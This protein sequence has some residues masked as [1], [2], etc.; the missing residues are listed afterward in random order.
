[1]AWCARG[2]RRTNAHTVRIIPSYPRMVV[3]LSLPY[4]RN[5]A[6]MIYYRATNMVCQETDVINS[7]HVYIITTL[8]NRVSCWR[9][10]NALK[11]ISF[12]GR[13]ETSFKVGWIKSSSSMCRDD[14]SLSVLNSNNNDLFIKSITDRFRGHCPFKSNVHPIVQ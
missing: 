3:I 6:T 13:V 10:W 1:M 12:R 14:P 4:V 9:N 11:L 8:Q 5:D 2:C 7:Q